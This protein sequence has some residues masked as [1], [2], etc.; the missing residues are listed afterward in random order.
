MLDPSE[1]GAAPHLLDY[2]NRMLISDSV[3]PEVVAIHV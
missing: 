1:K 3:T 2:Y